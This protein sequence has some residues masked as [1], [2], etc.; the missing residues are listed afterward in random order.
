MN[1][2]SLIE[3]HLAEAES[4]LAAVDKQRDDLLAEIRLFRDLRE[5]RPAPTT[6][7][8]Q[9]TR[10][11]Q[12][13]TTARVARFDGQMVRL[14]VNDILQAK[15]HAWCRASLTSDPR[16]GE[17]VCCFREA[18][19]MSKESESYRTQ[20]LRHLEEKYNKSKPAEVFEAEKVIAKYRDEHE[21]G[22]AAIQRLRSPLPEPNLCPQCWF[23]HERHTF[24]MPSAH[25][26]SD[27]YD[28][29]TCR[30]CGHIEDRDAQ[31]IG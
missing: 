17:L 5:K 6:A 28:R 3:R 2:R 1:E 10:C 12:F 21:S 13:T 27:K 20:M 30:A 24:M 29:M 25:P 8:G 7:E 4:A 19:V 15:L 9:S 31:P 18:T 22:R 16:Q 11:R 14:W 26:G 23:L